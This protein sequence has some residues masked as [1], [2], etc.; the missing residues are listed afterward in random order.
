MPAARGPVPRAC[1]IGAD[2]QCADWS[3]PPR[4]QKIGPTATTATT[5]P[6][7]PTMPPRPH[8]KPPDA[9]KRRSLPRLRQ[10]RQ[11]GAW[12]VY[13]VNGERC[14]PPES[15]IDHGLKPV[16]FDAPRARIHASRRQLVAATPMPAAP[17]LERVTATTPAAHDLEAAPA[18][19]RRPAGRG[20]ADA[21]SADWSRPPRRQRAPIDAGSADAQHAGRRS[22]RRRRRTNA[23]RRRVFLHCPQQ[24][25]QCKAMQGAMQ[26]GNARHSDQ[27]N[28]N[29][30]AMQGQ[31]KAMQGKSPD[32][33]KGDGVPRRGSAAPS[34]SLA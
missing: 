9:P 14:T 20:H 1:H 22:E 26:G 3:R 4:R 30:G 8:Q 11:I 7:A 17:T 16:V 32:Q 21:G 25:P 23:R 13:G 5:M 18:A 24:R 2:A 19:D 33:C 28:M 27:C 12:C 29:A 15:K 31:C 6:A 34:L 10:R